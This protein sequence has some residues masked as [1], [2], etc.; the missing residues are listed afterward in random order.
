MHE[1]Q[2]QQT[3]DLLKSRGIDRALFSHLESVK[4]LT[5][6]SIPVQMGTHHFAGGPPLVWYADGEFT[7]ILLDMHGGEAAESDLPVKTYTGYRVD[8]PITSGVNLRD[9][10]AAVVGDVSGTVGIERETLPLH[11]AEIFDGADVRGMDGWLVP[12][13]MVK[14]DEELQRLRYNFHLTDVGHQAVKDTIRAGLR[15]IDVWAAVHSAINREAGQR[16]PLGNDCVVTHR[17]RN[18]IGGWPR[19][20]EI[21]EKAPLI[22]D[23]STGWGGYW[24]DSCG[25]YYAGEMSEKQAKMHRVVSDALA[26]G[27][28]LL[29][30]GAIAKEIDQTVRQFIEDAGFPVYPHH[31]G[32]GVG[33]GLHE[34]P[35]ITP[36]NDTVL[37]AGMVLMLEPGIY[38]PGETGI[39]LENAYL[40]TADGCEVLTTHLE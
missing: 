11:L 18:N 35:R 25:A 32:H 16:V 23:L 22:V 4:W 13:R 14:T 1:L 34:E 36:Y 7:L 9:L 29:R 28:S 40:V 20:F 6:I 5:G 3:V 30:P 31:T 27:A 10:L 21:S 2:R 38:F 24:S 33:A 12:L 39:R 17:E 19:D 15:E 37:Q 26:L 8:G